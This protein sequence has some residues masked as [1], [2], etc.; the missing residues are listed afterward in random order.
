MPDS[1]KIEPIEPY[2]PYDTFSKAYFD[3]LQTNLPMAYPMK[4]IDDARSATRVMRAGMYLFSNYAVGKE[5]LVRASE[6]E[7][8]Q[9]GK[10]EGAKM[11]H[12]L[13]EHLRGIVTKY[14][15]EHGAHGTVDY[16]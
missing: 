12:D 8:A 4:E 11:A 15:L 14:D 6:E 1:T 9:L 10:Y 2:E 5:F 3:A 16:R 7:L 13:V